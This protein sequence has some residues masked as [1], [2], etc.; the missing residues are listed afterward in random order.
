MI[1]TSAPIRTRIPGR[2]LPVLVLLVLSVFI[3]YIDRANLSIAA[4]LLKGEL[5]ISASQL[6]ILLSSFFWT[7]ATFQIVSGW[8]VD[9][10]N[11]NYV[12]AAGFLLWSAATVTTG[13]AQGFASLIVLR[14]L[15]GMGE[16]V[17]Y[18]CYSK[19]L[20][21][22]FAEHQRG[23]ANSLIDA[24]SKCG[25]AVGML[26]GGMLMARFG[27]RPFFIILGLG[28][29]LWLPSWFKWMPHRQSL[30]ASGSPQAPSILEI[31]SKRSAW[32]TFVGHFCS[33]YF[34]YFLLTWLPFYLVRERAFSMNTMAIVGALA[35]F[36]SAAAATI[37]GW[38]S[39][40]SI[41]AGATPTRIR[42]KCT[43]GGLAS[44]TVIIAVTVVSDPTT[45][46][47]LLMF[48]CGSYGVYSSSHWAITQTLAG[49]LAAGKWS[50]LQNFIANL[51][52]VV[53]PALTG[54]VVDKTGHFFWAFAVSAAVV[55]IGAAVYLFG[56]G[57]VEPVEWSPRARR[58]DPHAG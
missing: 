21:S 1:E 12:L 14:L 5:G 37:A 36:V 58:Y 27:W 25:P 15:L 7:Y 16:S 49:P 13:L 22:H 9:R 18:P 30:A 24:G 28:S 42:K 6:G 48:A 11:V 43:V 10:F 33:N 17:A 55:L 45:S 8:L 3:N 54:F 39:D 34:L 2:P 38:L 57:R 53:A 35:Y 32:A 31:L 26:V 29:L 52:G 40:R 44:A 20:V 51:A 41:A 46:M 19:I 23:L 47:V 4:P 56:V 50:G